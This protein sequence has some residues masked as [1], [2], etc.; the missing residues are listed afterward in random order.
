MKFDD[1]DKKMRVYETTHD[2]YVMPEMYIVAQID[3]RSF[4]RLT[5][6]VHKFKTPFNAKMRDDMTQKVIAERRRLKV[7]SELP[8]KDAYGT[9]IYSLFE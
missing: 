9:F 3:R 6:E 8:I 5:K 7:D 2:Y 4:T 1:L